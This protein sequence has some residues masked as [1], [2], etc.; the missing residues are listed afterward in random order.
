MAKIRK[1]TPNNMAMNE[2]AAFG[3]KDAMIMLLCDRVLHFYFF[4]IVEMYLFILLFR[5]WLKAGA[6]PGFQRTGW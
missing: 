3:Y 2:R 1:E 6:N 4:H 5:F